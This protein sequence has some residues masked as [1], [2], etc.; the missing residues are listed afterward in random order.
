MERLLRGLLVPE[1]ES[2]L[3]ESRVGESQLW[4][5]YSWLKVALDL[6]CLASS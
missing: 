6:P 3:E 1:V 2:G 5:F 4:T